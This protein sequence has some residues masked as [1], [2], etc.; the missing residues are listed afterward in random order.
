MFNFLGHLHDL[1]GTRY[2]LCASWGP[3]LHSRER[4][5]ELCQ[6]ALDTRHFSSGSAATTRGLATWM[7][8]SLA[9]RCMRAAGYALTARQY[10]DSREDV[11]EGSACKHDDMTVCSQCLVPICNDCWVLRRT[12]RGYQALWS[13]LFCWIRRMVH[14]RRKRDMVGSHKCLSSLQ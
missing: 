3:K 7:D 1:V 12:M 13:V 5:V 10:W 2:T 14:S 9:G 8:A 6:T 4:L 11:R